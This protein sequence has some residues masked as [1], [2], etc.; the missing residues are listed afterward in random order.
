MPKKNNKVNK[1]LVPDMHK[2]DSWDDLIALAERNIL[3]A[4]I[5]QDELKAAIRVYRQQRDAGI[6]LTQSEGRI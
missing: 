2:L 3:W 6:P 4:K 5:R 1:K